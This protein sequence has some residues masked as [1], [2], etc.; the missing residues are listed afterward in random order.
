MHLLSVFA[1]NLGLVVIGG[2]TVTLAIAMFLFGIFSLQEASEDHPI[3]ASLI[4]CIV[5]A[6]LMTFLNPDMRFP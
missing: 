3:V 5:V 6:A 2:G 1:F 4:V